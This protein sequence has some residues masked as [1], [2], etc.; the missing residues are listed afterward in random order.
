MRL[1]RISTRNVQGF[2]DLGEPQKARNATRNLLAE[3]R[4]T[5]RI[6]FTFKTLDT[7]RHF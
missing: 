2:E 5:N 3:F 1:F 6:I 7:K 4:M